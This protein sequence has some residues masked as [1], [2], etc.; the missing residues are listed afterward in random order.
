MNTAYCVHCGKQVSEFA[1]LCPFCNKPVANPHA[2]TQVSA[3]P[4]T[5][6]R[7]SHAKKAPVGIIIA[8]L[9]IVVIAAAAYYILKMG[10]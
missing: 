4:K 10:G 2:P 1:T 6:K 7:T 5:W 9:A 3:E 8:C